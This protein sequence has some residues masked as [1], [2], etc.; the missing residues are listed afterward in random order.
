MDD[1]AA[2]REQLEMIVD[3]R[4]GL[5]AG[6]ADAIDKVAERIEQRGVLGPSQSGKAAIRKWLREYSLAEAL[7][8]V[9]EAFDIYMKWDGDDADTDAWE[10]A[11]AKIPGVL[12]VSR[13]SKDRPW[14]KKLFYIQGILRNRLH[15]PKGNYIQALEEMVTEWV[16]DTSM[17]EAEAKKATDWKEFNHAVYRQSEAGWEG[18]D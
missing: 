8:A 7:Y 14:L 3:W 9:D 13:M 17:M 2:R 18:D 11:F 10:L 1:L 12:R 6:K 4:D 5:E 15:N 16:A